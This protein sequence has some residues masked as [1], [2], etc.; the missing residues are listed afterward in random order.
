MEKGRRTLSSTLKSCI[1]EAAARVP[2]AK[3]RQLGGGGEGVWMR[4]AQASTTHSISWYAPA[5]AATSIAAA[6]R[7][8]RRGEAV[9]LILL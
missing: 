8:Q 7:I 3:R 6:V 1:R 5:S 2:P 9:F 4:E